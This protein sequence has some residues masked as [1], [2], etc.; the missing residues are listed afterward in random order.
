MIKSNLADGRVYIM[1]KRACEELIIINSIEI[2]RETNSNN[3][4]VD[5]HKAKLTLN[6]SFVG[7]EVKLLIEIDFRYHINNSSVHNGL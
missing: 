1:T 4:H 3:I 7:S 6:F 5:F 2:I